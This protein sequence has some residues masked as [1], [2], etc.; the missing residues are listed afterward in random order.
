MRCADAVLVY[1]AGQLTD[2][3]KL[4][5]AD[6]PPLLYPD[7]WQDDDPLERAYQDAVNLAEAALA[8][9]QK[10]NAPAYSREAWLEAALQIYAAGARFGAL[11]EEIADMVR[12]RQAR[13][14]QREAWPLLSERAY[15]SLGAAAAEVQRAQE[16]ADALYQGAKDLAKEN[17]RRAAEAARHDFR[18]WRSTLALIR[19]WATETFL[20]A[21]EA[22]G[23]GARRAWD[24]TLPWGPLA[25][26]AA[27][28][29]GGVVAA[30]VLSR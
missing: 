23:E 15:A 22:A 1:G 8:Y 12:W 29:V 21:S 28:A 27:L 25:A 18:D 4:Q 10:F 26:V 7:A 30:V 5:P 16:V 14:A 20:S 13:I 24:R 9:A 6:V 19:D 17:L 2:A 3:D 11:L